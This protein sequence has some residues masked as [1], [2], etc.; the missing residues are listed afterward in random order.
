MKHTLKKIII[1]T[2]SAILGGLIVLGA[3]RFAPNDFSKT[4]IKN[5][6]EKNRNDIFADVFRNRS[7]LADF[8]NDSLFNQDDS[9]DLWHSDKIQDANVSG[10]TK[11]EDDNSVYYDI[12]VD[13]IK[14]TSI[15]TKVQNGY[16]TII[17]KTKK[18][19]STDKNNEKDRFLERS[20][21]TSTFNRSFPLPEHI[22]QNKMQMTSEDDKIILK[23]PKIKA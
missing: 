10:I 3:L 5:D 19:G 15:Q 22:D 21:Y 6:F 9:F 1:P 13:D 18:S 17:G 4:K 12:Q 2:S 14:S 11:R 16:I 8:F 7:Q 23:F 20:V